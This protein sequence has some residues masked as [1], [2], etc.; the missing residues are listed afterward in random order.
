MVLIPRTATEPYQSLHTP[1]FIFYHS[2]LRNR[3]DQSSHTSQVLCLPSHCQQLNPTNHYIHLRL[4]ALLFQTKEQN[5]PVITHI[6]TTY[7]MPATKPTS[8]YTHYRLYSFLS[9]DGQLNPTN[10]YS[11]L[12]LYSVLLHAKRHNPTNHCIYLRLYGFLS[13]GQQLNPAC[14]YTH[15]S[16]YGLLFQAQN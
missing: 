16:L 1:G 7:L 9:H 6:Q 5:L 8:H 4:Y 10:H 3:T 15:F 14:H 2:R 13:H 11:H 12:R